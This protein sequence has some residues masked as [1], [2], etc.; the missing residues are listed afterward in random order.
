MWRKQWSD[1]VHPEVILFPSLLSIIFLTHGQFYGKM[2]KCC[3]SL[4]IPF[5][6]CRIFIPEMWGYSF[7]Q[8]TLP[9]WL[10]LLNM[11]SI[12]SVCFTGQLSLKPESLLFELW[13]RRHHFLQNPKWRIVFYSTA[14][15]GRAPLL[16][17]WSGKY[18]LWLYLLSLNIFL[19]II[20]QQLPSHIILSKVLHFP[21]SLS[22]P[23]N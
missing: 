22:Q 14:L 8:G 20:S 7:L 1:S 16:S 6:T 23:P 2:N 12:L 3:F 9:Y 21:S 11:A 17:S 18:L 5:H 19:A 13:L 15:V 10:N 4:K